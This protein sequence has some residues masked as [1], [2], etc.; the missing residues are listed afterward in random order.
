M[1]WLNNGKPRNTYSRH[2]T[3]EHDRVQKRLD[4]VIEVVQSKVEQALAV[5][6]TQVIIY[7]KAKFGLTCSCNVVANDA[8]D[9]ETGA[10]KSLSTDHDPQS[11]GVTLNTSGRTMFGGAHQIISLDDMT[12]G[13]R[14]LLDAADLMTD[15]ENTDVRYDGGNVVNC[16]IC[17]RQGIQ[18][19][20][21][22]TGFI[23][24]VMT[25]HHVK[26][27]VG[28]HM[29]RAAAPLLF[30]QQDKG[31]YVDFDQLI[32][33]YFQ[34]A[35]YS[36]RLNENIMPAYPKP[37][38]VINGTET[39]LTKELLDQHRG[40]H[41]TIRIKDIEQ[42]THCVMVFDLGVAITNGNI[43]EE[44]NTLN[45]DQEL[46]VGNITV[47]LPARTGMIEP[48]DLLIIPFKK[49]V[50][51]VTEAPKK[52]TAKNQSWEWVVTTRAVQR[53]EP[54]YN[55]GKGYAIK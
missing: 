9:I 52:R 31:G 22:A 35:E 50:L 7:K 36:I 39:E 1:S 18:P 14:V 16:G 26:A 46:T 20:F 37:I 30:E 2:K 53:K 17:Y 4:S 28:Y 32:P 11:A 40:K 49:Y 54:Q 41:I 42:F 19:G 24:N 34:K 51:K 8:L 45:Y 23:Y 44:A 15:G 48:E 47:V 38:A 21:Q 29:N 13:E 25:H 12:E 43:S 27:L 55:I 5:D 33:K 3:Y 10:G 6:S